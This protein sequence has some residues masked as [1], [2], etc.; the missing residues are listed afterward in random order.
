MI[1]EDQVRKKLSTDKI[2][3]QELRIEPGSKKAPVHPKFLHIKKNFQ[4]DLYAE[5]PPNSEQKLPADAN[6]VYGEE[7]AFDYPTVLVGEVGRSSSSIESKVDQ[8][9]KKVKED[10]FILKSGS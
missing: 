7:L 8:L 3:L 6:I 9:A 2:N 1:F 10:L 5:V 4:L